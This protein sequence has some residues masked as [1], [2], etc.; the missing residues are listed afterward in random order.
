M[1]FG[2]DATI[3][4]AEISGHDAFAKRVEDNPTIGWVRIGATIMLLPDL[5]VGG[6]RALEEIGTTAGKVS[7]ALGREAQAESMTGKATRD[8]RNVTNPAKHPAEVARQ[9]DRVRKYQAEAAAQAKLVDAANAKIRLIFM[10]DVALF[11]GATAG[12]AAMMAANPPGVV[13]SEAQKKRDEDLLKTIT[14]AGGMP[15]D[16]RLDIRV[17]GYSRQAST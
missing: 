3:Y 11:P 14:P 13:L 7:K 15:K 4:G 1:L 8:L 10:R 2:I 6:V 12:G 5:P 17:I 9:M 16:T